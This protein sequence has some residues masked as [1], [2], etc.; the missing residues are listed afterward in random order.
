MDIEW[1][2]SRKELA[3]RLNCHLNQKAIQK[4]IV[5]SLIDEDPSIKEDVDTILGIYAPYLLFS[6]KPMLPSPS[7]EESDGQ[8]ILGNIVQGDKEIRPFK[9]DF[10]TINKH[11]AIF[12]STGSGKTSLIAYILKQLTKAGINWLAI[13]TKRDLRSF[14]RE[15]V[16][17]LRWNWLKVNPLQPPKS[18]SPEIW[19]TIICDLFAHSFYWFSP[20]ENYMMEFLSQL[21]KNFKGKG[22][23]TLRELYD[24]IVSN[25]ESNRKRAE[26][27]A[28]VTNRLASLLIVL[29]DVIDVRESMPLEKIFS[30]PTVLEIDQLRRD[31][32]NF[33]VEY[34]LAYLFYHRMMSGQRSKLSHVIVCD[35][36]N[37]WFYSQRKWKETT[38]ELGIPFIETVPQ[39]IRDYCEGMIFASQNYLSPTVMANTNLKIVGFLGDGDDIEAISKSLNLNE[40]EIS[41]IQKLETGYWLV[42]KAG[43]KPFLIHSPNV[44]LDKT[45]SDE[46]LEQRMKHVIEE[47]YKDSVE[48]K[49]EAKQTSSIELPLSEDA[50]K[51][52]THINDHPFQGIVGRAKEL[53]FSG[54]RVELAK[55]ELVEKKLVEELPIVLTAKKP[56]LF[57]VPTKEAL[58]LL[59]SK[60]LD[61]SQWRHIG[62]VGFEHVLYE[63]LVRYEF[64]KLGYEAHIEVKLSCGRKIDVLA[65]KGEEKIGVEIELSPYHHEEGKLR[66]VEELSRLFILSNSEES[67]RAIGTRWSPRVPPHHQFF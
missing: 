11:I 52:L 26:Y 65:V 20:S 1:A 22:Y 7:P 29:K 6:K 35:E 43:L 64:K 40:E 4:L 63:V 2:A 3:E 34:I 38:V 54:R 8:I 53:Q 60:G 27:F 33:L 49:A 12:G 59:E 18:V 31:E 67:L 41:A 44:L 21:Y 42:S 50:W 46:E 56:T 57:L 32:A 36:A 47:L 23:P 58:N 30:H 48:P 13:D 55:Q 45:I 19:M 39:I 62:K 51:L 9:V 28:V 66:G 61:T 16:W 25:E 5:V 14:V 24:L 17:L 15:G 10:Q 37:R